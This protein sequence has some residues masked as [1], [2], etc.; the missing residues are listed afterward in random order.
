MTANILIV[1]DES[2]LREMMREILET[3]GY[4]TE[5]AIDG[6]AAWQ[7]IDAD[8]QVFDLILLDKQMPRMNGIDLLRRIKADRRFSNLPVVMLTGDTR[9]QDIVEGLA[10]G[11][12]Y[13]LTKPSAAN[14]LNRVIDNTLCE[15]RTMRELR[16]QVGQQQRYFNLLSRAEWHYRTLEDAKDL[17]LML[18][19]ASQDPHRTVNGYS[20]LL[21]NAVEHGNLG[22]TYAEKSSLLNEGRWEQEV[23]RRLRRSPYAERSVQVLLE[24]TPSA[25]VVTIND[26][27]N[28]FDWQNYLDFSPSRVFDLHGRGIAMSRAV[29]FDKLEYIG[30]GSSVVVTVNR[31]SE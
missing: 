18:A 31:P 23:Q 17:A 11:A 30:N 15:Y 24:I 14:I 26:Q 12:H 25:S 27:G 20:E 1:D 28:G 29:S 3:F 7:R 5:T 4:T 6:L 16:L 22:I 21:I 19:N 13:Y 10:A 9:E 8:P 2:F